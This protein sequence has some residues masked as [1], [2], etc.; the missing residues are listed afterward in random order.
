MISE[1]SISLANSFSHTFERFL[2][3]DD[4]GIFA[5][6]LTKEIADG[7]SVFKVDP[8]GLFRLCLLLEHSSSNFNT[9]DFL[10]KDSK[11]LKQDLQIRQDC[12]STSIVWRIN[13]EIISARP[14]WVSKL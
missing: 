13:W 1:S 3:A 12:L 11:C 5:S 8:V 7:S 10:S 6:L 9:V 4:R 2:G 14:S